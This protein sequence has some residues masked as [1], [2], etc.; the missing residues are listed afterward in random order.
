[1]LDTWRGTARRY[2]LLP[3]RIFLGVTF[4][5][6]GLDKLTSNTFFTDAA[7][8]SLVQTLHGTHDTAAVPAMIDLALKAPHGFGYAIALGEI[9]VG[10][11]MLAGLLGRVAAAGGALISLSL[12][13]TVSWSTTP[14]Y[15]GNDL[16]YLMAW[17]PL[18][19]AG[20]PYLSLDALIT[21]R[22]DG[23]NRV[24]RQHAADA[25]HDERVRSEHPA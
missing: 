13:L 25:A 9:A 8:G 20:T 24:P 7:N 10:L 2:A 23:Q 3:L 16:A 6:A 11:G 22:R 12:W 14:Y 18:V 17:L 1:M 21:R 5:Y 19:L 15:Y 4:V